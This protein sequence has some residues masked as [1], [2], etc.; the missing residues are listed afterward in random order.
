MAD[1]GSTTDKTGSGEVVSPVQQ[2][3]GPGDLERLSDEDL[4][5]RYC[6][7]PPDRAAL[8]E[9]SRR[10]LR[11]IEMF[12][13]WKSSL[14]PAWYSEDLFCEAVASRAT[15]AFVGNICTF[16]FEGPFLGWLYQVVEKKAIDEQRQLMGRGP[17]PRR[18]E[19]IDRPEEETDADGTTRQLRRELTPD[20]LYYRSKYWASPFEHARDVELS[21]I[22]TYL[23]TLHGQTSERNRKSAN[24]IKACMWEERLAREVAKEEGTTVEYVWQFISHDYKQLRALFREKLRVTGEGQI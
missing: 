18:F 12:A 8:E 23:L 6:A 19:S 10:C 2:F 14:C 3:T 7:D 16:R 1:Y 20:D 4:I 11:K 5:R 9:L 15:D 21:E 17:I 22:V 13:R 24:A